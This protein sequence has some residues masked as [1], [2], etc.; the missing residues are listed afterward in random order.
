MAKDN[1]LNRLPRVWKQR[2]SVPQRKVLLIAGFLLIL[3]AIYPPWVGLH[4]ADN[5]SPSPIYSEYLGYHFVLLPP[6]NS[7]V[8][9]KAIIDFG[10]L[11]A[12]FLAVA[13]LT[14]IGLVSVPQ[15]GVGR[16]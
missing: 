11:F 12:Q 16:T 3:L 15:G 7:P 4:V 14:C 10:A 8:H 9:G 6:D 1:N 5:V 2:M 13:G